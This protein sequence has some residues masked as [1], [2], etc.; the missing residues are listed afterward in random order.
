VPS[1]THYTGL[2]NELFRANTFSF[3]PC[4]K[5]IWLSLENTALHQKIWAASKKYRRPAKLQHSSKNFGATA[6]NLAQQEEV[7][8][9]I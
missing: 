4:R 3:S 1:F 9:N 8:P 7:L 5:K 2:W 6:K